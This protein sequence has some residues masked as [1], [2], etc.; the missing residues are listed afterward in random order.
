MIQKKINNKQCEHDEFIQMQK[1][2]QFPL[3]D[4]FVTH[5]PRLTSLSL[6]SKKFYISKHNLIIL[7]FFCCFSFSL[8]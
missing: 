3:T 8:K 1:T 7:H 6:I 2:S 4:K 5:K